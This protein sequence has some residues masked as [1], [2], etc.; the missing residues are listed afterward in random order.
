MGGDSKKNKKILTI[1]VAAYNIEECIER[2]LSS[3]MIDAEQMKKMEVLIENDGSTD[4]TAEIAKKFVEKY[5]ETFKLINKKNGGYGSTVNNSIELATGKYFKILDGDD[6]FETRNLSKFLDMLE[7]IDSDMVYTPRVRLLEYNN[8]REILSSFTGEV[9]GEEPISIL[10]TIK[11]DV[12]EILMFTTAYKTDV[13]RRARFRLP[14][15][16][17]YTD[18]IVTFCPITETETI[19]ISH[20]P[21]YV[22]HVGRDGQSTSIDTVLKHG[23]ENKQ[24]AKYLLDF[25]KKHRKNNKIFSK[26]FGRVYC[27]AYITGYKILLPATRKNLRDIKEFDTYVKSENVEVWR[28][29]AGSKTV[30]FLRATHFLQL[31]Y[32][33][34][35]FWRGMKLRKEQK[36]I[37]S[38][39]IS[40]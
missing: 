25:S 30:W 15:H 14:E 9:C 35:H 5:P 16:I 21:I 34:L 8:Q 36:T 37:N 11:C 13:L 27:H 29:M 12:S 23:E 2:C 38:G 7:K 10:D 3:L 4:K 26:C 33:M 18:N 31:P 1:S 24:V 20:L 22:Y 32:R 39:G 28:A 6:E 17:L 19:F 40:G